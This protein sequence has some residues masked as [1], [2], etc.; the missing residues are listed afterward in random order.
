M[1]GAQKLL[2]SGMIELIAMEL[3]PNHSTNAKQRI[4]EILFDAGY[5]LGL[6]GGYMGPSEPV[7]AN[8]TDSLVLVKDLELK[9]YKENV[10]WR[11]KR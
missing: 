3:Q 7:N 2:K 10:L 5:E 4:C 1:E 6:H 9:R 8:Y 11:Q